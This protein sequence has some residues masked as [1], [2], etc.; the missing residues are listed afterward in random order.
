MPNELEKVM[1]GKPN[2]GPG[3]TGDGT[4]KKADAEPKEQITAKL[5]VSLVEELRETS[6]F[7]AGPPYQLTM[8]D[9]IEQGV[10]RELKRLKGDADKVREF[11]AAFDT[12]RES[13][14]A[15]G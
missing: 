11:T 12:K 6:R 14:A 9:I 10:R 3:T 13:R 7:L 5:P 15:N 1:G 8:R 2:T 4:T